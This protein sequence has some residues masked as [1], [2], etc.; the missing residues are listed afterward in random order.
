MKSLAINPE[1]KKMLQDHKP[2]S[3]SC[4]GSVTWQIAPPATA[5]SHAD[6]HLSGPVV[7]NRILRSTHL[8]ITKTANR[9][10]SPVNCPGAVSRSI[11]D[12]TARKVYPSLA[13]PPRTVSSYLTF[14]PLSSR[15]K[16]NGKLF[17]VALSPPGKTGSPPVRW[18]GTLRCPDFP[19][20]R[21]NRRANVSPA[22]SFSKNITIPVSGI[23]RGNGNHK[24]VYQST[25]DTSTFKFQT[26]ILPPHKK[27]PRM[28]VGFSKGFHS[29]L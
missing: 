29:L 12:L 26:F 11:F 3:V 21:K 8:R 17:S 9:T 24:S 2:D 23:N 10:S 19:P 4:A 25:M 6:I 14:S 5:P 16:S 18:C 15:W 27:S 28:T 7:A 20:C 1:T 13:L 22:A